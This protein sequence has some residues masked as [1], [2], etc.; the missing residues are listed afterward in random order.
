MSWPD[1]ADGDVFRRLEANGFD[2]SKP[3]AV[4][5]NVDFESWPPASAALEVL[6][7]QYGSIEVFEP[8]E[9]G[10]GYVLFQ[11]V[12]PITYEGVTSVQRRTS[13]TMQP[14]GGICESWGVMH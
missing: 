10:D 12:G 3:Y 1:D 7:S 6:R 8:D 4:D 5:Y 14:F 9:D 13:S 2:F 11:V